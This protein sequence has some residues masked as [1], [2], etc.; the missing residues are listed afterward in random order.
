MRREEN[1]NPRS[2]R[3]IPTRV[4]QIGENEKHYV[5]PVRFIPTR[6][7]QM[8]AELYVGGAWVAVHPHAC[9]ADSGERLMDDIT[10]S[11]SSPRVWGRCARSAVVYLADE[12]F[13]PTR[14]GQIAVRRQTQFGEV[15]FIPTRVGQMIRRAPAVR[16]VSRFIP[17]RVGQMPMLSDVWNSALR[18]IPTRVGQIAIVHLHPARYAR[19]I[20]T[21]VG[22]I[23]VADL[24]GQIIVRFIPTRVGQMLRMVLLPPLKRKVHPHACGADVL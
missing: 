23:H 13:I 15:R 4:G 7:G 8:Q 19:F 22:Q 3:F 9:G 2:P 5:C 20:P 1:R 6:V 24:L 16:V 11:G 14:V 10:S 18:F 12:R 17:T 21:R